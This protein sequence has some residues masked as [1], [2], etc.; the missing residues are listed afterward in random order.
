MLIYCSLFALDNEAP[1]PL[2]TPHGCHC[3]FPQENIVEQS[4]CQNFF[5]QLGYCCGEESDPVPYFAETCTQIV[6]GSICSCALSHVCSC[7]NRNTSSDVAEDLCF[8]ICINN[9]Q[10]LESVSGNK[11]ACQETLGH[12]CRRNDSDVLSQCAQSC[13]RDNF[14]VSTFTVCSN[15]VS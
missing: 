6:Q 2:N 12:V 9:T 10:L 8:Q 11:H 14:C 5:E 15:G 13:A 1:C 7:L 4:S 3:F